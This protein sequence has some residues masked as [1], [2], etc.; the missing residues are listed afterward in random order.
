MNRLRYCYAVVE[1]DSAITADAIYKECGGV[2]YEASGL[3]FD[4]R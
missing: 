3:F 4:M 1:S 2:E